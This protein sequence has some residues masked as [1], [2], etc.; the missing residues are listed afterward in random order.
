MS[1][2]RNNAPRDNLTVFARDARTVEFA[3]G[4]TFQTNKK[5]CDPYKLENKIRT[6]LDSRPKLIQRRRF[7]F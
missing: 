4:L 7:Y 5:T 3:N 1:D 6:E 2:R